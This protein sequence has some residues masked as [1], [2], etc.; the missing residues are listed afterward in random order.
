MPIRARFRPRH[1]AMQANRLH[2]LDADRVDRTERRHRFLKDQRDL[3]AANFPHRL[4]VR[5]E[6]GKVDPLARAIFT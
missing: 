4:A 6:G 1:V 2:E 3:A 5:I